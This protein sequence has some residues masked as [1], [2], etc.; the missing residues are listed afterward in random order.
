MLKF[1]EELLQIPV[2]SNGGEKMIPPKGLR[3][4]KIEGASLLDYMEYDTEETMDEPASS[5]NE[6]PD[7][8]EEASIATVLAP[9]GT[10]SSVDE[11]LLKETP[12]VISVSMNDIKSTIFNSRCESTSTTIKPSLTNPCY[13]Y[14][15]VFKYLE[16]ISKFTII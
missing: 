4:K 1:R 13:L 16:Q 9:S 6:E 11:V 10:M 2:P 12:L 8:D 5:C 3:R 15:I 14:I 7:V